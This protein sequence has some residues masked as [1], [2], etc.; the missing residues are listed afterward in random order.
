MLEILRRGASAAQA[1]VAVFDFDGTLSL[2]RT[3]WMDIMVRMM[4]DD[5]TELAPD[6]PEGE[7]RCVVEDYVWRLTGKDTIYQMIAFAEQVRLRGGEPADPQEY[8]ARF[9]NLL[10]QVM[11]GRIDEIRGGCC[12]PDRHLVPGARALLELLKARGLTLYLASGTDHAQLEEEAALLDIARYFDGGIYGAQA[13]LESFSKGMLIQRILEPSGMHGGHLLGFG[14]GPVEIQ[15]VKAAG[16]V[17]V[18]IAGHEPEY[19]ATDPWKRA[20]LAELG[21]DYIV[22]NYLCREDL[23]GALFS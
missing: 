21:T 4:M 11:H 1:T 23:A 7:L 9:L 2:I 3:G 14:D 8:K 22:P 16:G 12:E 13:D 6:E 18:G 20:R 17:A 10:R 5:L 19:Q 15:E